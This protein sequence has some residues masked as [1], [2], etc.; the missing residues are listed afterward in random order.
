[1]TWRTDPV[2]L[3]DRVIEGIGG[4]RRQGQRDLTAAVADAISQGHHLLAEAPTGSGKSLAY[5]VAAVASGLRVVVATSTI[6]LQSQLIGKDIPALHAHGGI[7]FDDALLKGRANYL[8]RAKLRAAAAP[9]ALFEQPVGAN[10]GRQQEY[11][12]KFAERSE[13]GD[14]SEV[15]QEINNAAWAAVSCTSAECPG[16]SEC[17]D[18]PECFAER[19]RERARDVSVLVVNHALYCS[20]L[21]S[22]GKVLPDHD[23]V[24]LDEVHSFPDNATN[25]FAGDIGSD[26]VTRLCGMLARAG[27]G[28]K[29][30]D[31]LNE[32]GQRLSAIIEKRD[33]TVQVGL[34]P[35]FGDVLAVAAERLATANTK[36]DTAGNDVAKRTSRL[37]VGRLE[38]LRRLAAPGADDV[39]WVERGTGRNKRVRIAPVATGD[40]IGRFLLTQRPV[41]AVSATLGG[42]PP[43]TALATQLGL[44]T[45]ARPGAWGVP[46]DGRTAD[47][48]CGPRLRRG[49]DAFVVRL[50]QPGDA[51]RRQRST[52]PGS[53]TRRVART[54]RR[55][56]L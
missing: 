36:L 2:A 10:F 29:A 44:Q 17:A 12:R 24:I 20:H 15:D 11:L 1:M 48:E 13:S 8:C 46:D 41:I 7:R 33:G 53:G 56:R 34:D 32:A 19:A 49:A 21:A 22:E 3:L 50:A 6:A 25:A 30:V 31:A 35:E 38:V 51:V 45:S 55:P 40:T 37:A 18:G 28:R 54:S 47:V 5:L 23:L 16:R 9:D 14:R 26:A 52:R 43:F 42:A 39:V 4:E 27:A